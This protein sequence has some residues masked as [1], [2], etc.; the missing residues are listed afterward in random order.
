SLARITGRLSVAK[1][2]KL[3]TRE[4]VLNHG[5]QA[6]ISAVFV[7]SPR[8][9]RRSDH[10]P[11]GPR[12]SIDCLVCVLSGF[13]GTVRA[14]FTAARAGTSRP[15]PTRQPRASAAANAILFDDGSAP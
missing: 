13:G 5:G 3:A 2:G 4:L 1:P 6:V 15:D 12:S 9:S 7:R 14:R 11:H 10:G 8:T